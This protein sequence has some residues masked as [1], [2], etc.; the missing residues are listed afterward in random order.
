MS[1]NLTCPMEI[2]YL[3]R[4]FPVTSVP[5]PGTG[6][7]CLGYA[8]GSML[9]C[10]P[11]DLRWAL[12]DFLAKSPHE[13]QETLA[14]SILEDLD[15]IPEPERVSRALHDLRH[16]CFIPAD[17]FLAYCKTR[18]GRLLCHHSVIFFAK[19]ERYYEP[20]AYHWDTSCRTTHYVGCDDVHYEELKV[21]NELV[22]STMFFRNQ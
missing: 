9:R 14:C 15:A 22:F 1:N 13:L 8:L 17:V 18:R 6:N 2:R 11:E 10:E 21:V 16:G 12:C 20:V 3:N 19:R 4:C 7:N 5:N